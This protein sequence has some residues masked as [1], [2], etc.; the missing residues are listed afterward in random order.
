MLGRIPPERAS[1]IL[2]I[3]LNWRQPRLTIEAVETLAQSTV[4]LDILI[5]DNGS[6]D[7]SAELLQDALPQ[8]QHI[9][10]PENV[11][12]AAGNNVG[13]R[14]ALDHGHRHALLINNDAFAAPGMVSELLRE[15]ADDIA[16]VAPKIYYD[17][18]RDTL[19]FAGADQY[20]RLLEQ[21]NGGR[22]QIDR[23]QF[24]TRDVDYLLGTCLLVNMAAAGRVGLLDE[25]YFMYYEDLD[26]SQRMRD[27]G[28][29][30]RWSADARLYH[31]VSSSTGGK[32][33]P[34]RRYYLARSS[35]LFFRRHARRGSP[36]M[37]FLYRLASGVRALGYFG[38]TR[39]WSAAC[40]Y[41][42][43]VRDGWR[44]AENKKE[45]VI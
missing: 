1:V 8:H 23:G 29:R 12:F 27:E 18:R 35:V 43:G 34:L 5:I 24:Q 32:D 26:W 45:R 39:Q 42:R 41:L 37:I 44:L 22:D 13:L 38:R 6:G 33:S 3:V 10:L 40:A 16:L 36:V 9:A 25:R 11:G 4:P 30:L 19:W 17:D 28:Y 14:H 15:S 31:R 2:A 20:P 21:R 7:G